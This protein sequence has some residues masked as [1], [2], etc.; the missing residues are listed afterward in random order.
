MQ[1]SAPHGNARPAV[2]VFLAVS[3]LA[4][5]AATLWLALRSSGMLP[6]WDEWVEMV[7]AVSGHQPVTWAWLW[8]LLNEHR[9]P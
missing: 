1:S 2:D 3:W 7:P 9:I 4:C 8:S 5:V 6:K